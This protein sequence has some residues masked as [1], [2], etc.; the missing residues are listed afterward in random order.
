MHDFPTRLRLHRG[1]HHLHALV[2]NAVAGFIEDPAACIDGLPAPVND[3]AKLSV[4]DAGE[5]RHER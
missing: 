5:M 4:A 2:P 1:A 3:T